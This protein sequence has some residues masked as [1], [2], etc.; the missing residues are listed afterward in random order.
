MLKN[1]EGL[2]KDEDVIIEINVF[3]LKFDH[4]VDFGGAKE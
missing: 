1:Q 3:S 4:Y 2:A